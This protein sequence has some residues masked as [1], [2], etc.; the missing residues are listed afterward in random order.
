MAMARYLLKEPTDRSFPALSGS[1]REGSDMVLWR[2]SFI[3]FHFILYNRAYQ[4]LR[5]VFGMGV[6]YL[7]ATTCALEERLGSV[8]LLPAKKHPDVIRI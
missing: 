3:P 7:F 6:T 2:S 4:R 8:F 1:S 5:S